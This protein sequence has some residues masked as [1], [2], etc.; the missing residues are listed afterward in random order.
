MMR[1]AGSIVPRESA[2][3]QQSFEFQPPDIGT[4]FVSPREHDDARFSRF[5]PSAL[6]MRVE[7]VTRVAPSV[8]TF[9]S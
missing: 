2:T 8:K 3:S 4:Y 5:F 1:P 9:I 6:V 7:P